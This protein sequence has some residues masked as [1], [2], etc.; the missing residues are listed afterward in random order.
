MKLPSEKTASSQK[1][2][3]KR[4]LERHQYR[5]Q[6]LRARVPLVLF[7]LWSAR[8]PQVAQRLKQSHVVQYPLNLLIQLFW[9]SSVKVPYLNQ[10]DFT[11]DHFQ[12]TSS[13]LPRPSNT[14]LASVITSSATA[15]GEHKNEQLRAGSVSLRDGGALPL[16]YKPDSRL[17]VE[18]LVPEHFSL[19]PKAASGDQFVNI[20]KR[21]K[22]AHVSVRRGIHQP[23]RVFTNTFLRNNQLTVRAQQQL[24]APSVT[25]VAVH[26]EIFRRHAISPELRRNLEAIPQALLPVKPQPMLFTRIYGDERGSLGGTLS[27]S[28]ALPA[29]RDFLS[30]PPRRENKSP[31][32]QELPSPAPQHAS[33]PPPQPPLDIGRLSEE[34]YRHIQRKIRV[35]R[36]RRGL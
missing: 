2:L 4:I 19:P 20:G 32:S 27:R 22:D 5:R 13:T 24:S 11:R 7:R 16:E 15:E 9:P 28:Y 25:T 30:E 12:R 26:R 34:V 31:N 14:Q 18:S 6:L 10:F 8:N 36:E 3:W 23:Q 35:E 33:V 29:L 17:S 1:P 21:L